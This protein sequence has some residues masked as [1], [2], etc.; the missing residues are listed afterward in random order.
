MI[1]TS[2][3]VMFTLTYTNVY[4]VGH[5]EYSQERVYMA[6]LMDGAMAMV[7]LS[8]MV[9]MMYKNRTLTRSSS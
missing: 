9:L 8:F 3:A 4:E 6:L 5:I 7:M 1:A 2:T